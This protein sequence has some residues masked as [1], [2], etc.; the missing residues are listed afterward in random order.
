[1]GKQNL[2]DQLLNQKKSPNSF[3]C[4]PPGKTLALQTLYSSRNAKGNWE[5]PENPLWMQ[6]VSPASLY[7]NK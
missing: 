4:S 6:V 1:M 3:V 7:S 2:Y 5:Y